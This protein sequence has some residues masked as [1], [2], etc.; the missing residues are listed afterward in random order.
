MELSS[1]T[2]E[3]KPKS[4]TLIIQP[5]PGIGDMVWFLPFIRA[6][7]AQQSTGRV[8]V[9]TK[10]RSLADQLLRDEACVDEV[11]WIERSKK[12]QGIKGVFNLAK[13]IKSYG[14]ERVYIMHQSPRYALV[15]WLAG[16]SQRF[17][18]GVGLQKL[19]LNAG[20]FLPKAVVNEHPID[21]AG[22]YLKQQAISLDSDVPRLSANEAEIAKLRSTLQHLPQPWIAIGVGCSEP[23]RQWGIAN[24]KKLATEITKKSSATIF[25]IGGPADQADILSVCDATQFVA[26]IA[27]PLYEVLALLSQCDYFVGNDTGML[28][29]AAAT[30]IPAMGIFGHPLSSRL[31]DEKRSIYGLFASQ[32]KRFQGMEYISVA[33]VMAGIEQVLVTRK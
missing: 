19:W 33:N 2:S 10:P 21:K 15:A 8:T 9:L 32:E 5:L 25:F 11:L 6:I 27:K 12:H 31:V 30:G 29:L 18:Y 4:G 17:G 24:F 22:V 3:L 13:Q 23:S 20:K 14:F 16:I 28:N 7:A 1:K 26:V